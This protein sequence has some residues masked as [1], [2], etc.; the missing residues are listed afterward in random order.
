MFVR[1]YASAIDPGD[2]PAVRR[3]FAEDVKPAFESLPG[4]LSMEFLL[5]RSPNAGGLVEGA[6]LSRW[7]SEE[8][9]AEA[10]GSRTVNESLV[11]ILPFLQLEPV[12]RVFEI[13]V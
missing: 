3:I 13:V 4:C 1:L 2:V 6:A 5:G 11:R 9:L 12:I 7:A 8:Q 10:I